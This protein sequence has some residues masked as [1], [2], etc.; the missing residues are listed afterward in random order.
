MKRLFVFLPVVFLVACS[1]YTPPAKTEKQPALKEVPITSKSPEAIEHFRKGRDLS[2]NLRADE[3]TREFDAAIKLD[4]DFALAYLM[5][6]GSIIGT[7]GLEDMEQAKARSTGVSKPEQMLIDAMLSGRHGDAAKSEEQ[8]KELAEMVP[9]DWRVHAGL[10]AQLYTSQKFPQAIA[11]LDKAVA[12]NPN[13]GPAYNMI[14]YSYL[15]QGQ[16]APAIDALTKYATLAPNEPNP[17]DSLGEALLAGGRFADAEAAFRK[18]AAMSSEFPVAWE[19][20]AYTKFFTGDWTAGRQALGEAKKGYSRQS[21]RDN[22]DVISA[23][24]T[25]AQGQTGEGLKQLEALAST[26]K[27][28][29]AGLALAYRAMAQVESGRYR[30]AQAEASKA[31]ARAD[32]G[33]MSPLATITLRRWGLSLHAAAAG[34]GGDA[35]AVHNDVAA[36]QNEAAARPDDPDLQSA[37]HFALGMEAVAKKDMKTAR[38]HFDACTPTDTYCHWQALS[39]GMKAGDASGTDAARARLTRTYQRDPIYLYARTVVD[40][41]AK[42]HSN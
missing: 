35:A 31:M 30:E 38:T 24:S 21:Q 40:R 5:R 7:E 12:L 33:D 28:L 2:E 22:V 34:L 8:W 16:T 10:G 41:T 15:I 36:L 29:P 39:A 23:M 26:S 25:L 20:V 6:G 27:T 1:S 4:P 3:A 14:G 42:K 11:S 19:G 32:A 9:D 17:H 18:A 37:V 13:A